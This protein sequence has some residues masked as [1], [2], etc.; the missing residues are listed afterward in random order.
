M[1]LRLPAD[2]LLG[3]NTVAYFSEPSDLSAGQISDGAELGKWA[4]CG[5]DGW[6]EKYR[7]EVIYMHFC[8]KL[9]RLQVM[10]VPRIWMCTNEYEYYDC[11]L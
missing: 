9:M 2:H 5:M 3:K 6:H 10:E 8:Y 4:L 7:H 11:V 1:P